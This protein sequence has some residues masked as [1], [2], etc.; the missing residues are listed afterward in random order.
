MVNPAGRFMSVAFLKRVVDGLV[1]N[2]MNYLHIHFTDV[3]SFPIASKTY[4]QLAQK[5]RISRLLWKSADTD[6]VYSKAEL[7]SLVAYAADRGVRVV[8]EIE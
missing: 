4:P 5:G 3:S 8:P 1:V 6:A 7:Q 2:K